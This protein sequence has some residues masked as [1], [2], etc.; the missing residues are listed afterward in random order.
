[1]ISQERWNSISKRD[2]LGHIGAEILRAHRA[3]VEHQ[4]AYLPILE[5]V[6]E[7][8]DLSLNDPKWRE[9]PRPLLLFR[10]E[11][12]KAY[13]AEPVNLEKLYAAL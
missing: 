7:L 2:Q 12:A 13:I 8:I 10:N 1:M 9:N 4:E 6:L 3:K 5:R 11:I